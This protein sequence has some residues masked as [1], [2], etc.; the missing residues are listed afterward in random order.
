MKT[1]A[2]MLP[3]GAGFVP[4]CTEKELR[5]GRYPERNNKNSHEVEATVHFPMLSEVGTGPGLAGC[6]LQHI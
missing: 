5:T 3:P 2:V 1:V 6:G 4:L